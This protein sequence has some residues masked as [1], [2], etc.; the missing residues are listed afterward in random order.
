MLIFIKF[1][2]FILKKFEY[3]YR[4]DFYDYCKKWMGWDLMFVILN[5]NFY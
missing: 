5:F 2:F 1:F 4:I 3:V